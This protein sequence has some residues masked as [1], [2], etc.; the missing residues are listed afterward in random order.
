MASYVAPTVCV[1]NKLVDVVALEVSYFE[2]HIIPANYRPPTYNAVP[3]GRSFL[4][5][6]STAYLSLES[7]TQFLLMRLT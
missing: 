4:L 5:R 3:L 6:Q 1:D 2:L 7:C